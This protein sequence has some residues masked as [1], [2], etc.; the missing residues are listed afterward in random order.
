[1]YTLRDLAERVG[2]TVRGDDS[3]SVCGVADLTL[4][5]AGQVS[6]VTNPKYAAKLAESRAVAV[7]V[8][9]DF[10]ETPMPAILCERVDRSVARL[11]KAFAPETCCPASGR[12]PSAVIDESAIVAPDAA[13]GPHVVIEAGASVGAGS[14]LHA[15]VYVGRDAHIGEHCQLWPNVV[16]RERCT[17]GDRV[18]IHPNAVLG[19]DGFG[20]YF[21][22]GRHHKVPH[23]GGVKVEDDVE[24]GAGTCIDRA[25]VGFTRIGCG[26]KIDNLVHLAH[27]VQIGEHC[28]ILAGVLVGGSTRIG[29]RAIIG[30]QVGIVD[31]I[32]I[33]DGARCASGMTYVINDV[34]AGKTVSGIPAHDHREEL[35][36]VA[37]SRKLP[38]MAETLKDLVTRVKR[39]EASTHNQS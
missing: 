32:T 1:M 26:T 15:G 5:E 18:E 28:M 10:G 34:P 12:H 4:A 9:A 16:V 25:K 8:P 19:A 24:I 14:A 2:G 31:N 6:W 17:I 27:N 7:L 22:E 21:D 33:G 30:G 36:R 13:I 37:S 11:F 23:I 3:V 35:R 38:A 29:N 39:L 20:F